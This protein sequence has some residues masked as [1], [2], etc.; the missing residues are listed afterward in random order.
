MKLTRR[1]LAAM[2]AAGLVP[3]RAAVVR[4]PNGMR[5]VA[6]S[7]RYTVA[8]DENWYLAFTGMAVTQQGHLVCSY[9]KTDAHHR[10][11]T[12]IMIARS[13]DGG[14]TW[15]SHQS[16]AHLD[17]HKD[18]GIW[19]AP[20]LNSL[21]DGRLVVICDRGHRKPGQSFP[22]LSDW[23]KPDRG[24]WNYL[25]LSDDGGRT[26]T[27]PRKVDDVGGEPERIHELSN[28]W[29]IFTRTQSKP[30]SEIKH[31]T[32]PWGPNY[33]MSVG[34][35]SEDKGKTW[36]RT[37]TVADSP[38]HGDCEV[39]LVEME[40]GHIMAVTRIGDGN[41]RYGQP[42]R[43]LHS[44]DYGLTWSKP[45]LAPFYGQR[46][47]PGR[48]KLGKV[49]VTFRNTWG[50]P[51]SCAILFDPD[52]AF[53]FQ[54]ASW[55]WDESRCRLKDGVMEIRTA[56]GRANSVEF[57]FYPVEDD[58]SDVEVEAEL[59][60]KE[61]G[62]EGCLISAGGWVRFEPRRVSLADRPADGFDIDAT[63]WR[64]YKLTA[65]K[66]EFSIEADGKRMLS[67]PRAPVHQRYVRLGSRGY[68]TKYTGMKS[69]TL[70]RALSVKVENR[71]DYSIDW[72]WEPRKGYPD[73]FR[74]DRIVR[75]ERNGSFS[76]GDS[77]YSGWAQM[78]DGR[79]A[80]ADYTCGDPPAKKPY[81]RAYL[82][83]E[84]DLA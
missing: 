48:L 42:S 13:E 66:G 7:S 33:Y 60:V 16:I 5:E 82:L 30:T 17:V 34:V 71:R 72:K 40:P 84:K 59:M 67:V 21:R 36:G 25:F 3:A 64:K 22:M 75:L 8:R 50:T 57:G 41:G 32:L 80:V 46:P 24:M 49:L 51:G 83:E 20:E 4:R 12:D 18:E 29:W 55:I 44:Y 1:Q 37:V 28:G 14:R 26:W 56:D 6:E 54:P 11:T 62:P 35:I 65:R 47:I 76:P 10:T 69:R 19:V 45:E 9:L 43:I 38:L 74:R 70:W 27:G 23:Q 68:A 63:K 58:D 81:V 31:P 77:G 78:P 39:G 61:A 79:I 73:Q 53:G 15:K 2:A 52:E